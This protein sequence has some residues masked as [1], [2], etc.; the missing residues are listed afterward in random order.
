MSSKIVVK[1]AQKPQMCPICHANK[2]VVGDSWWKCTECG[3]DKIQR[4]VS[5]ELQQLQQELDQTQTELQELKSLAR[6]TDTKVKTAQKELKQAKAELQQVKAENQQT[7]SDLRQS[8]DDLL[9]TQR[10]L[11]AIQNDF[12][13]GGIALEELKKKYRD[14]QNMLRAYESRLLEIQELIHTKQSVH[15]EISKKILQA[16]NINQ[17]AQIAKQQAESENEQTQRILAQTKNDL[18]RVQEQLQYAQSEVKQNLF[19]LRTIEKKHHD[20]QNELENNEKRL[21]EIHVQLHSTYIEFE[22][23]KQEILRAENDNQKAQEATQKAQAEKQLAVEENRQA[24]S[25]LSQTTNVL[26]QTQNELNNKQIE[27]KQVEANLHTQNANLQQTQNDLKLSQIDHERTLVSLNKSRND[28]QKAQD[29]LHQTRGDLVMSRIEVFQIQDKPKRLRLFI[30]LAA[31]LVLAQSTAFFILSIA[32]Q[33]ITLEARIGLSVLIVISSCLLFVV[34]IILFR[35][36]SNKMTL[37]R[38]AKKKPRTFIKSNGYVKLL[39]LL[40]YKNMKEVIS[41]TEILFNNFIGIESQWGLCGSWKN[42]SGNYIEFDGNDRMIS[43]KDNLPN[44]YGDAFQI[45]TGIHYNLDENSVWNKRLKYAILSMN[46]ISVHC[47]VNNSTYI[48]DREHET[49]KEHEEC[50]R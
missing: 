38:K 12:K 28:L 36:N 16:Q 46:Q 27:L 1:N 29:D 37:L 2:I 30:V 33:K 19:Y 7:Q 18:L 49:M 40:D 45:K 44:P 42:A 34:G 47:F 48:L 15:D 21:H 25:I 35:A 5:N 43:C 6:S 3:Y 14:T 22:Q 11:Q 20:I 26:K 32:M 50:S 9:Q 31:I 4:V 10:K 39:A 17:E 24:Q 41:K 13:Q 8:K 23:I